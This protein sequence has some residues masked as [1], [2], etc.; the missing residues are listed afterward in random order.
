MI[1]HPGPKSI[2]TA[3]T[4]ETNCGTT[5]RVLDDGNEVLGGPVYDFAESEHI[6]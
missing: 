1:D 2:C 5:Q 4:R 6:D 3:G